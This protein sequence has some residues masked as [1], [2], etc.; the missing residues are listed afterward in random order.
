MSENNN[1]HPERANPI[2]ETT[3]VLFYLNFSISFEI[4]LKATNM[5]SEDNMIA[6]FK[7]LYQDFWR[8]DDANNRLPRDVSHPDGC[9][10]WLCENK[11][12]LKHGK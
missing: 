4:A 2:K 1:Y 12:T 3:D 10:C 8:N 6:C 7:E 9:Y 5:M 11:V